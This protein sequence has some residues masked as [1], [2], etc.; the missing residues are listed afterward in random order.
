MSRLAGAGAHRER[1]PM[2]SL[3]RSMRID[4]RARLPCALVGLNSRSTDQKPNESFDQ[5]PARERDWFDKP[6][7]RG[8]NGCM[9]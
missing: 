3:A 4:T 9:F 5:I 6:R 1:L 2:Q 7:D 8:R